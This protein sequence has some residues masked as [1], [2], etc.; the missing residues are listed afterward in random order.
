M[1]W[2]YAVVSWDSDTV[3][4]GT[5]VERE[6]DGVCGGGGCHCGESEGGCELH[7]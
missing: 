3:T 5:V 7:V 4:D 1:G 6:E 2:T